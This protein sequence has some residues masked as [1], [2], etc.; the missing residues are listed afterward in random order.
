M[1]V[2]LQFAAPFP[3]PEKVEPHMSVLIDM[4]AAQPGVG[5]RHLDAEFLTQFA[6]QRLM[7]RFARFDLAAGEFPVSGVEASRRALPE[8][9][10][11]G[12]IG[13]LPFDDGSGNLREFHRVPD[14]GLGAAFFAWRPA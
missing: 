11:H 10:L 12:T 8:K 2:V 6:Q 14:C 13:R 7:G 5:A 9:E 1:H 4:L 3:D